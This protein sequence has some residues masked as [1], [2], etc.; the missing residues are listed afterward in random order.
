M[1]A[2]L[3]S[4]PKILVVPRQKKYN[5]RNLI[6]KECHIF[7]IALVLFLCVKIEIAY[8]YIPYSAPNFDCFFSPRSTRFLKTT[9]F[10]NAEKAIKN[11]CLHSSRNSSGSPLAMISAPLFTLLQLWSR[12]NSIAKFNCRYPFPKMEVEKQGRPYR[13]SAIKTKSNLKIRETPFDF[14]LS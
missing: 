9:Q 2:R 3:S 8:Y 13:D 10:Q 14:R 11:G 5:F 6:L 4:P 12:R 1:R 7:D